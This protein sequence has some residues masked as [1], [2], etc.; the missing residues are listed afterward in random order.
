[1]AKPRLAVIGAGIVGLAHAWAAARRGY[2]VLLFER[3]RR[4][5]GASVR[6][7]GMVWPVGQPNG[8]AHRTAIES[9]ELWLE[10]LRQTGLWYSTCGSLHLAYRA[11]EAAVLTEFARLAPPLGYECE[12]LSPEAVLVQSPAAQANELR[13]GLWS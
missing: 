2:E 1:N 4:A 8:P 6:N 3:D 12:W 7:F 11:D 5:S 9:R 13:G 10:L